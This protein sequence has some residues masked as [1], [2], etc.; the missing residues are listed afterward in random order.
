V[1]NPNPSL[2][3]LFLKSNI[4]QEYIG[5][6]ASLRTFPFL[7]GGLAV[8]L[9]TLRHPELYDR[10]G[11]KFASLKMPTWLGTV[12]NSS[13]FFTITTRTSEVG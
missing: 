13:Q 5:D 7:L 4:L 6:S 2:L 3:K 11:S 8:Q 1:S 12:N 10:P 9:T